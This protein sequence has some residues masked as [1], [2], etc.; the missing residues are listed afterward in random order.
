M[1]HNRQGHI[2]YSV[3]GSGQPYLSNYSSLN[4]ENRCVLSENTL[5]HKE[6]VF[7]TFTLILSGV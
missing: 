4:A 5:Q 6:G 3:H 2:A 1:L 7:V